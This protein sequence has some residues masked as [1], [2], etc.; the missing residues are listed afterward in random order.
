[1]DGIELLR[2]DHQRILVIINELITGGVGNL[3]QTGDTAKEINRRRRTLYDKLREL[4]VR[5]LSVEEKLLFP[6]LRGFVETR[7]LVDE[8]C[9][10]HKRT[11]DLLGRNKQLTES[12]EHDWDGFLLQLERHIQSHVEREED[13]LF[14]RARLLLGDTKLEQMLFDAEQVTSIRSAT[15]IVAASADSFALGILA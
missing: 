8:C 3:T 15:D 4:L 5:H 1:M 14:P 2:N 6:G 11:A 7:T 12:S 13:W 10:E 9:R